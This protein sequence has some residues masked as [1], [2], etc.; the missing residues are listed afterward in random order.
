MISITAPDQFKT[1]PWKNGLGSTIEL[2]IND[3]GILDR[4]DWRLSIATVVENGAFSDFAGYDRTLIL[5]EGEGLVLEH[6]QKTQDILNCSL[7]YAVFDGGSKTIGTLT[8]GP[9]KDLN[10]MTHSQRVRA[11]VTTHPSS[12]AINIPECDICFVYSLSGGAELTT[13]DV[14]HQLTEGH[15]LRLSNVEDGVHSLVGENMIMVAL[16]YL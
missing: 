6:D 8:S 2:A 4:F 9:I 14:T 16:F 7:N 12:A 13:Q 5:V 10:V 15:L 3:G 1:V 11:L